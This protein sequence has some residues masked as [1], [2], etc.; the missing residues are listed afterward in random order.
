LFSGLFYHELV[1]NLIMQGNGA[2][3][4]QQSDRLGSISSP[5]LHHPQEKSTQEWHFFVDMTEFQL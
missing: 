2:T 3:V 4:S 1:Y 5:V